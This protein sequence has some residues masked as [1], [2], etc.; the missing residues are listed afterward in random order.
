MRSFAVANAF[1]P[2][3]GTAKPEKIQIHVHLLVFISFM[4]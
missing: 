2:T 1:T 3:V 4:Q